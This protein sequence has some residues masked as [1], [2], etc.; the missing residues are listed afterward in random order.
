MNV[1]TVCNKMVS[2][3]YLTTSCIVIDPQNIKLGL[4]KV[5]HI[6][7]DIFDAIPDKGSGKVVCS[8]ERVVLVYNG[9]IIAPEFQALLV[10]NR[11]G[12]E[13][14]RDTFRV[15][16]LD[17]IKEAEPEAYRL[18]TGEDIIESTKERYPMDRCACCGEIFEKK[19]HNAKYCA[20][21]RTPAERK[22]YA[23]DKAENKDRKESV[24]VKASEDNPR[25]ELEIMAKNGDDYHTMRHT[26]KHQE[27]L[28]EK[29]N[30]RIAE[31]E[32]AIKKLTKEPSTA[33][34]ELPTYPKSGTVMLWHGDPKRKAAVNNIDKEGNMQ[35]YYYP[36][37]AVK[38]Y[39]YSAEDWVIIEQ[40]TCNASVNPA[41]AVKSHDDA[42]KI[43]EWKDSDKAFIIKI[44]KVEC[45][46][47]QG[48]VHILKSK[49]EGGNP[50]YG[51]AF[52]ISMSQQQISAVVDE[53]VAKFC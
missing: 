41:Q 23:H 47:K 26:I 46:G 32:E 21:H 19:S 29:C 28:I 6:K 39:K 4:M 7:G 18:L 5:A 8:P 25:R 45:C 22:K 15:D 49:R 40:R 44:A 53:A 20:L 33:E 30:V 35:F 17:V 43:L 16:Y 42:I 36:E 51:N 48:E 50:Y 52:K 37:K 2:Y 27:L 12:A 3:M 38:N 9:D 24:T 10:A 34:I 1:I 31:L 14:F 11:N 13:C